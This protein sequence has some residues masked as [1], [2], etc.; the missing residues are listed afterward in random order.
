MTAPYRRN[1][2]CGHDLP[3]SYSSASQTAQIWQQD[4]PHVPVVVQGYADRALLFRVPMFYSNP[5]HLQLVGKQIRR[6]LPR[7]SFASLFT[8][9]AVGTAKIVEVARTRSSLPGVLGQKVMYEHFREDLSLTE[10][11]LDLER[12]LECL[13][14]EIDTKDFLTC[15][16]VVGRHLQGCKAIV[17]RLH[18]V[19]SKV[20]CLLCVLLITSPVVGVVIGLA[21]HRADVGVAASTVLIALASLLQGLAAWF[22]Q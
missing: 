13:R 15:E 21:S 14:S 11:F 4:L 18:L 2:H 3:T 5:T 6:S 19:K 1:F 10:G 9:Y 16:H 12:F 7:C 17:I 22:Q 20:V 8:R